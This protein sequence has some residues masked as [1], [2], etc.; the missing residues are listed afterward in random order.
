MFHFACHIL[1]WPRALIFSPVLVENHMVSTPLLIQYPA[2]FD[3]VVFDF[4][5]RSSFNGCWCCKNAIGCKL[6]PTCH[7][8]DSR[9]ASKVGCGSG[10]VACKGDLPTITPPRPSSL[11]LLGQ[12]ITK[13]KERQKP[14]SAGTGKP[15]QRPEYHNRACSHSQILTIILPVN[16]RSWLHVGLLNG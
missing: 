8:P 2:S 4:R 14:D 9:K 10:G 3:L 6:E 16:L 12:E 11:S 5:T 13:N 7:S 1:P 15:A